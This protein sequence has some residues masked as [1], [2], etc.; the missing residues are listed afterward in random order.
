MQKLHLVGFNEG[1]DGLVLRLEGEDGSFA[2][3][4][5]GRLRAL[6]VELAEADARAEAAQSAGASAPAAP[7]RV[8]GPRHGPLSSLTPREMQDR[9]RAGR[10]VAD[11]AREAG[12]EPEWVAKFAAPV[13]A[14]QAAVIEAARVATFHKPR[15]GTSA[16]PLGVS[17]RRNVGN[18]GVTVD[19]DMEEDAWSAHQVDG[20]V[21]LVTFQ[22]R[23]RGRAQEGRWTFDLDT[24]ELAGAN[25]LGG[26][27]GH[28]TAAGAR[29]AARREPSAPTSANSSRSVARARLAPKPPPPPARRARPLPKAAAAAAARKKVPVPRAPSGAARKSA[30]PPAGTRGAAASNGAAGPARKKKAAAPPVRK[31]VVATTRPAR[32]PLPKPPPARVPAT[33]KRAARRGIGDVPPAANGARPR[34]AR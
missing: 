5:D 6:V 4:V 14:E 7:S 29:G 28:V 9:L 13:L 12:V 11:V 1:R 16:A 2:L 8:P 25:K 19:E 18:R 33:V 27:L 26:Q 3:P 30:A 20:P 17:V 34:R 21:W 24:G 31:K 32:G 22:Y 15:V 23:S 10:S